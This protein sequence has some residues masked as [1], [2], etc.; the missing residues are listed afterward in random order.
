[1]KLCPA[2]EQEV[3]PLW[4]TCRACGA[5]LMAP[6]A[7]VATVGATVPASGATAGATAA[8]AAPELTAAEQF[9]APAVLQP[10]V[11]WPAAPT[12]LYGRPD[13]GSGST[14]SSS[15][16]AGKWIASGAILVF[17]I[18]AV[19]TAWFTFGGSASKPAVPVALAPRTPT[20]GLPTSLSAIVRIQ[21]ESTRH[22][23][24]QAVEQ[25]GGGD[26][27]RLAT[28]QPNYTW[29]SGTSPSVVPHTVSVAQNAGVVT[30]AVSASNHDL[31]AFG[32]WS[33]GGTTQYVTMEHEP[34]CAAADAPA[35]GWSA[36]AGGAASDLPDDNP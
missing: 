16:D 6:P 22:T 15:G 26:T 12:P 9:F 32:Q 8:A 25:V 1:V 10:V 34:S 27:S 5:L 31:C 3:R 11:Q 17:V 35:T 4:P 18:A 36:Q 24:L 20:E 28:M 7:P 23:A 2:C 21:A 30:I 19:A 13:G 33:A 29:V 14:A